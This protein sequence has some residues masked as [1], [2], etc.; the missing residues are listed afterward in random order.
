MFALG[1]NVATS[2]ITSVNTTAGIKDLITAANG[3]GSSGAGIVITSTEDELGTGDTRVGL[4]NGESFVY[5][6]SAVSPG[7]RIKEASDVAPELGELVRLIPMVPKNISDHFNRKQ[8]SGLSIAA[9]INLVN[10]ARH[11]QVSSKTTGGVGQVYAVGGKASGQNVIEVKETGQEISTAIGV[12]QMD[13]SAMDLMA[14]GHTIK[15]FQTGRA[16]KSYVVTP[17]A[18]TTVEI[19]IF[20]AGIAKLLFSSALASILT[21]SH[22]GSVVWAVRNVA[23]G[24]LRFEVLSG[25]AS[26][27]A[28]LKMDDWVLSGNGTSYAGTTPAQVFAAANQGYFQIRET[29]A[30]TYFDVDAEGYDEFVTAA[31][32]PFVFFP[33]HSVRIGDQISIGDEAPLLSANKGTFTIASVISTTQVTFANPL[34]VSEG[35]FALGALGV[36]SIKILD[37][38]F[39]TYRKVKLLSPSVT[40]PTN[41]ATV[42]VEPGYGISLFNEQQ[43]AKASLP[44]RLGFGSD[45]VPG[46]SGYQYWT[47]LKQ[48]VQRTL[49]GYAPESSTFPGVRAAGVAIE[50]REPQ[51]QRV[52]ISIKVKTKEGVALSSI[53]DGIKSSVIGYVN[54]LGLGQD[55]ILS[56]VVRLVQN[57]SGVEALVL[58]LPALDAERIV[59]GDSAIART[60]SSEVTVS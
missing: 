20:A 41:K 57:S 30:L 6:T 2:L 49:D 43:G 14:P 17:T 25:T 28:T 3:S 45:P 47:G 39:S 53:S 40:D 44:N 59:I 31:S 32:A 55:V 7:I 12:L 13:R 42:I 11:V 18:F 23:R 34:V 56:E 8:I 4:L 22:I 54:S 52:E 51:I 27:P 48:R 26:L 19:Q 15:L 10:G 9:D 38:G 37:Q 60:S 1:S 50:A 16:K 46:T 36:D 33:Y 58:V 29:D 5:S 35:P 21:Y 24:R